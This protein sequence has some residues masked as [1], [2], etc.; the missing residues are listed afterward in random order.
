MI[1]K[2]CE[3]TVCSTLQRNYK[4]NSALHYGY[5]IWDMNKKTER[6]ENDIQSLYTYQEK[7]DVAINMTVF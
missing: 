2:K 5:D 3:W 6:M 7:D 4:L 1:M